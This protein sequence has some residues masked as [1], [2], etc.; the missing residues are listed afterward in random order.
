MHFLKNV[1]KHSTVVIVEICYIYLICYEVLCTNIHIKKC[2]A[3][4]VYKLYK[5][6]FK[7]DK[8]IKYMCNIHNIIYIY[9]ENAWLCLKF[10]KVDCQTQIYNLLCYET[11]LTLVQY[12]YIYIYTYKTSIH[13]Q[14]K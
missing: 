5:M 6:S 13:R 11:N 4:Y 10:L 1:Y 8:S 12:S 9:F 7:E 14:Y 2:I 3:S